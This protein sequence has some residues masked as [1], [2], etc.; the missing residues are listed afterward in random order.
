MRLDWEVLLRFAVKEPKLVR[1]SL[2]LGR[3]DTASNR[4]DLFAHVFT[5]FSLEDALLLLALVVQFNLA[6]PGF[7]HLAFS[8]LLF[9]F[10]LLSLALLFDF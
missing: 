8:L 6:Q 1:V 2:G 4:R 3:F 9:L 5:L 10:K 7:C